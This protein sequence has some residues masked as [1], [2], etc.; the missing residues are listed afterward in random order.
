[1]G[2]DYLSSLLSCYSESPFV[3][4]SDAFPA[5][6]LPKPNLPG[7][8]LYETQPNQRL[9]KFHKK[10]NWVAMDVLS[11]GVTEWG[12]EAKSENELLGH[13]FSDA[14]QQ[15]HNTI[16]RTSGSTGEGMFAPFSDERT[17]YANEVMLDIYLL[18][19]PNLV[20]IDLITQGVTDIGNT[21]FGA[22]ASTGAGRFEVA[23]VDEVKFNT[24]SRANT[25]L[26]LSACCPQGLAMDIN[27]SFYKPHV[28]FGRHGGEAVFSGSPFK[29]PVLAASTGAV[30]TP[31]TYAPRHVLG[32][33]VGG[34]GRLS[35]NIPSAVHQGFAPVVAIYVDFERAE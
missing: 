17:W 31:L 20:D 3:V 22:N 21:G 29:A 28:H 10:A 13:R 32:Q 14:F 23:S 26:T 24:H 25:F 19:D 27:R 4:V 16:S 9:R 34:D 18:V 8:L 2:S 30:L 35:K 7:C 11:R 33:G 6:Y 12:D 1:M 15:S 5:G